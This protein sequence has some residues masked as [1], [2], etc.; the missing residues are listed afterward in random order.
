MRQ[1]KGKGKGAVDAGFVECVKCDALMVQDSPT[2]SWREIDDILAAWESKPLEE[3]IKAEKFRRLAREQKDAESPDSDQ[4]PD[5]EVAMV[6][7]AGSGVI[8]PG[9]GRAL[10]GLETL[11]KH[12][13]VTGQDVAINKDHTPIFFRGFN[14][15]GEHSIGVCTIPWKC[16]KHTEMLDLHVVRGSAGLL[17]SKPMLKQMKCVLDMSKDTLHVGVADV[18]LRLNLSPGDHYEAPLDG[19]SEIK[20]RQGFQ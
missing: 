16:G 17:L 5:C 1:S 6:H 18:T 20:Q 14:G 4:E 3:L 8:D 15:E 12:I 7:T 13:D 19:S 11:E 10:I 2:G 9:C